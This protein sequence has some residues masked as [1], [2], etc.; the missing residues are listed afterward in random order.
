MKVIFNTTPFIA[1][2]SIDQIVLLKE[3]YSSLI[4]PSAVIE[5]VSAGGAIRVTKV[6]FGQVPE[7]YRTEQK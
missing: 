6:V 1:L 4:T 2:A 3:I 7:T 5:E